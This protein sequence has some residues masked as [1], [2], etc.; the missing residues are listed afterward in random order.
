VEAGAGA[1]PISKKRKNKPAKN[2]KKEN[3]GYQIDRNIGAGILRSHLFDLFS[4]RENK[5]YGLLK[6]I[7]WRCAR[8]LEM[9]KEIF[10][11]LWI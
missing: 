9:V 10:L 6:E 5:L 8:S 1:K 2:K 4:C 3:R 7:Q 11:T